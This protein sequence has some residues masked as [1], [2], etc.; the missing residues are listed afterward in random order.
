MLWYQSLLLSI[1][2]ETRVSDTLIVA[3]WLSHHA[4]CPLATA[5]PVCYKLGASQPIQLCAVPTRCRCLPDRR[6]TP[7]ALRCRQLANALVDLACQ[8]LPGATR[9]MPYVPYSERRA[10][11]SDHGWLR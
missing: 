3:S 9:T 10:R 7:V 4:G 8:G 5:F 2:V 1:P 11:P 6:E